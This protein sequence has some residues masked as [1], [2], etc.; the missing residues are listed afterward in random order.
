M[1]SLLLRAVPLAFFF[2]LSQPAVSQTPP[3]VAA[4]KKAAQLTSEQWRED[5]AF[6]VAEMK[7]RHANLYHTVSRQK[8]EAA[9]ADLHA[10]IPTMQRNEIVVGLMR[11]AAMVGDGHTRVDPRKDSKFGF[12]SLPLKLYLFEDGLFVRAARPDYAS[13]VGAEIVEIGGVPV[14]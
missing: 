4:A 6:M 14:A 8:F 9:V 13:L 1:K 12:P 7:R 2:A 3:P 10:R 5:L 11:I